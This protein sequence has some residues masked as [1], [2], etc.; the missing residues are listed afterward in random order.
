MKTDGLR[1]RERMFQ[2]LL[3]RQVGR[4]KVEFAWILLESSLKIVFVDMTVT[5][6]VLFLK[7]TIMFKL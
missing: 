4:Q 5:I 1:D 6:I 3:R 7:E 2:S